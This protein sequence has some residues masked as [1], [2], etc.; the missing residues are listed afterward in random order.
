MNKKNIILS[1]ATAGLLLTGCGSS[2]SSS[3]NTQTINGV[4]SDPEIQYANVQLCEKTDITSCLN[5]QDN[6]NEKGEYSLSVDSSVVLSD[7]MLIAKDGIDTKTGVDFTGFTFKAA[8]DM[9]K[10]TQ[11]KLIIS[12]LTTMVTEKNIAGDSIDD[13]LTT[14]STNLGLS[15]DKLHLNPSENADTQKVA[16]LLSNIKKVTGTDFKDIT[17]SNGEIGTYINSISDVKQKNELAT[18]KELLDEQSDLNMMHKTFAAYEQ[19]LNTKEFDDDTGYDKSD[20]NVMANVKEATKK[21][22]S[23]LASYEKAS[24]NQIK[25]VVTAVDKTSYTDTN[26]VIA[27]VDTS[28]LDLDKDTNEIFTVDVKDALNTNIST[29]EELRKYYYSSNISFINQAQNTIATITDIATTDEVYLGI[30]KTYLENNDVEKAKDYLYNKIFKNSTK[31]ELKIE[32]AKKLAKETNTKAQEEALSLANEVLANT[33]STYENEKLDSAGVINLNGLINIYT[34]IS[35]SEKLN[36]ATTFLTQKEATITSWIDIYKISDALRKAGETQFN[37]GENITN[38]NE[39]LDLAL[40]W[41]KR[42]PEFL[43]SYQMRVIYTYN[44]AKSYNQVIGDYTK[45]AQIA[46]YIQEQRANHELTKTKTELQASY[47]VGYFIDAQDYTSAKSTMDSISDTSSHKAK[48]FQKYTLAEYN[49]KGMDSAISY[50]FGDMNND[51]KITDP[52]AQIQTLTYFN[53]SIPYLAQLAINNN[54]FADAKKAI[55]KAAEV[56]NIQFQALKDSNDKGSLINA[57]NTENSFASDYIQLGYLKLA[58]LYAQINENDLKAS[59]ITKAEEFFTVFENDY[60]FS[61]AYSNLL[62][63]YIKNDET[64]KALN[65]FN[66]AVINSVSK[67]PTISDEVSALKDLIGALNYHQDVNVSSHIDSLFNL[68]KNNEELGYI[69]NEGKSSEDSGIEV[70]KEKRITTFISTAKYY[71]E[72]N[73]ENK[74]KSSLDE[75]SIVAKTLANNEDRIDQ[76]KNLVKEYSKYALISKAKTLANSIEYRA[77]Q[78]EALVDISNEIKNYDAFPD[79]EGATVDND[80]DGIL[81]FYDYGYDSNLVSLP[82]DDDLDND[83]IKNDQDPTPFF[84]E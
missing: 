10:D 25:K 67:A 42:I 28:N 13:A 32:I 81:D 30:A 19:L 9:P 5:V 3:S 47:L 23:A 66:N 11:N 78:R 43:N 35:N 1:I 8:A 51:A 54:N 76:I 40:V 65:L 20:A 18:A 15:K 82:L 80:N 6:T 75:A 63:E 52:F 46:S 59:M 60:R 68:V 53:T 50:I 7:Y 14:V 69:K 31:N 77:E 17:I 70:Q 57:A 64:T 84:K 74:V 36:E 61:Q 79:V 4:V 71:N 56:L 39:T 58:S 26:K 55:D 48:A 21:V 49:E 41:A 38:V 27:N 37:K 2:S 29:S 34:Q 45:A 16:L 83:G 22:V 72:N 24:L 33:K 12:P 62:N 73:L 44:V